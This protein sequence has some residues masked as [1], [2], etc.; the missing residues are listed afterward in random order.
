MKI[1]HRVPDSALTNNMTGR[2]TAEY[3]AEVDRST[4]RLQREYD[5]EMRR[6]AAA[7]RRLTRLQAKGRRATSSRQRRNIEREIRVAWEQ[8]ELRRE[9]LTRLAS[10]MQSTPA[11]ATHRGDR[12]F[13][14]VPVRHGE[15]F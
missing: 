1:Q 7:G 13:R 12:S 11:G 4:E 8:V 6:S 5:Q 9:E 15:N 2:L 3:Q 14:P 10:L